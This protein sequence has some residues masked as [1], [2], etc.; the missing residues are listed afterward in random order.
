LEQLLAKQ[1]T[2]RRIAIGH[3]RWATHGIPSQYNAHPHTDCSQ[4]ITLIQNGIVENFL[5]LREQL[6]AEGHTFS[7]ETDTEVI[8]HLVEKYVA[9]GQ[10]LAESARPAFS[11][12]KGAHALRQN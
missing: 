4:E 2:N 6:R 3:T 5:A 10:G 12:I 7:S 9:E 11:Q 8:V 1:P